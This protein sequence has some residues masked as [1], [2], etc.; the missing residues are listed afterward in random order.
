MKCK[1]CSSEWRL[2][3]NKRIPRNCPICETE[4]FSTKIYAE[5]EIAGE[6]LFTLLQIG[7]PEIFKNPERALAEAYKLLPQEGVKG[8]PEYLDKI[9]TQRNRRFKNKD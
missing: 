4:L 5:T 9:F 3:N 2:G 6:L 8:K 7:G 1:V